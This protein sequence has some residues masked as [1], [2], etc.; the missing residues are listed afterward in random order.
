MFGND[1]AFVN[2]NLFAGLFGKDL[3]V[4]LSEMDQAELLGEK[5]ASRFSPM[6][7]RPMSGYI[8][9]P[10]RV[11]SR[12]EEGQHMG[13]RDRSHGPP[14]SL[15]EVEETQDLEFRSRGAA[16]TCPS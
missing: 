11:E 16:V 5:G 14:G 6:E 8:V 1:A 2:G 4:R 7:G 15:Q 9:V 3:F 10:R 13:R 12:P